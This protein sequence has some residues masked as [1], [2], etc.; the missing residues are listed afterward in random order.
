MGLPG[1]AFKDRE[2]AFGTACRWVRWSRTTQPRASFACTALGDGVGPH[3]G[4]DGILS[5]RPSLLK[6]VFCERGLWA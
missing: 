5:N 4:V 2:S 3:L 6:E 1:V